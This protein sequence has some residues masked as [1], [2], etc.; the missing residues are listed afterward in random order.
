ML[1]VQ[2]TETMA[3]QNVLRNEIEWL[4][5]VNP[6]KT[7]EAEIE[8]MKGKRIALLKQ[9][10]ETIKNL[11]IDVPAEAEKYLPKEEVKE[12]EEPIIKEP[13]GKG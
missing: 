1:K 8:S 12:P 9:I 6:P 4:S 3:I 2:F 5:W 7:L 11:N 13:I 10:D